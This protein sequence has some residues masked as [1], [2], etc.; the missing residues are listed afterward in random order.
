MSLKAPE[1]RRYI[2][3]LGHINYRLLDNKTTY[4]AE[5]YPVIDALFA[6]LQRI[7]PCHKNGA[8]E[9]WLTAPRGSIEDFGDYEEWLAW[10][11]VENYEEFKQTWLDY[12]PN[13]TVWYH[14]QAVE[15]PVNHYRMVLINNKHILEVDPDKPRQYDNAIDIFPFVEWILESV[16]ACIQEIENGT[17]I[18]RIES[19]VPPCLRTGTI[20]R[21]DLC[22]VF[23][24]WR[25]DFLAD[26]TPEEISEFIRVASRQD[27]CPDYTAKGGRPTFTAGEFFKLCALGYAANHYDGTDMS[28]VEQYKKH[29]DGRD[30]GLTKIDPDSPEAFAEWENRKGIGH[31]WEVCRGGN[32]THVSCMVFHAESGYYLFV[33]GSSE[34]RTVEAVRFYLAIHH[35]G[36]PVYMDDVKQLIARFEETEKIGIVPDGV[37]PRYCGTWFPGENVIDFMNLPFERTEEML[38]YCVWQPLFHPELLEQ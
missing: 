27:E 32:S 12:F 23:P 9:L 29:A 4:T 24:E 28:P 18:E 30:D 17:Y 7:S 33:S 11:M 36:F 1:L 19:G 13:E 22:T 15:D 35:A 10:E 8:R 3:W 21:R 26:I 16:N 20:V 14:F 2:D 38:P 37:I 34:S 31:P 25:E 6:Q 5:T